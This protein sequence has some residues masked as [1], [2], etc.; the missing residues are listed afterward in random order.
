VAVL[1]C[2]SGKSKK[3][4]SRAASALR[5]AASTL[6]RSQTALGAFLRRLKTR[7]GSPKAI[8]ATAHKL[9]LIIFNM[10]KN[11]IEYCETGQDYYE[12]QYRE[13]LVRGLK[14]RAESLGFDLVE[15]P[16][17]SNG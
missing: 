17:N 11:G 8:T 2:S 12:K 4:A 9:A 13:R 7:L 10:L 5:M 1:R 3:T 6:H 16:I 14:L 15:I